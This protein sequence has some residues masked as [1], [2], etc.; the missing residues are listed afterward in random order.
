MSADARPWQL[1]VFEVSLKKRQKLR[2]LIDMLGPLSGE[3]CLLITNGDN[4][5]SLN[6]HLRNAGG[7]WTWC[8]LEADGIPAMAAFLGESV[9]AGAADSLPFPDSA[10]SRVVVVDV[11]EHLEDSELLDREIARI[12][13]PGGVA[14]VT[15]PSGDERLPV[16]R[17]KR[18]LGMDPSTYGHVVQGFVEEELKSRLR[19]VGL[20]PEGRGAYSR[21]FTE[22][23]EL[24][25]NFGYVKVL[26]KR[27]GGGRPPPGE[28]APRSQD[29]L[30]SIG[31]AFRAYRLVFPLF[32]AFSAL[33]ALIPG[34]G[35]Y[36]VAVAARRSI[37]QTPILSDEQGG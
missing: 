35:G 20:S 32:R 4:P 1:Q 14:I 12:L 25:L 19:A 16:A 28:I 18:W 33:D 10:F 30:G 3:N 37:Q 27:P 2:L 15:T 9:A 11:H 6:H 17:M 29:Q 26:G 23:A 8:E 7:T 31:G 13:A 24:L 34:T 22:F 36:A 21:F 5:G